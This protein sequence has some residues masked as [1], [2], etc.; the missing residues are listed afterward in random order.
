[1]ADRQPVGLDEASGVSTAVPVVRCLGDA[2][3]CVVGIGSSRARDSGSQRRAEKSRSTGVAGAC[4]GAHS[5]GDSIATPDA[6]HA[7]RRCVLGSGVQDRVRS[8]P[9]KW[10]VPAPL[11]PA[12][13]QLPP[14]ATLGRRTA[15]RDS[16]VC[17]AFAS[18]NAARAATSTFNARHALSAA[19]LVPFNAGKPLASKPVRSR[20][21]G[22]RGKGGGSQASR[23]DSHGVARADFHRVPGRLGCGRGPPSWRRTRAWTT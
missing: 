2:D 22:G 4:R 21:R 14:A 23:S 3:T 5:R 15:A 19:G 13:C 16:R 17:I 1:L 20:L 18:V 8:L 7:A 6:H 11:D 12:Y 9:G 10:L